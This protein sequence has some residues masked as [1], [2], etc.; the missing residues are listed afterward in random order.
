[1]SETL[2]N[3]L[4]D[5]ATDP[6]QLARFTP[7]IAGELQRRAPALS[8]IERAALLSGSSERLHYA[9]AKKKREAPTSGGGGKGKGKGRKS[10]ARRSGGR[11]KR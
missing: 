2:K 11:K 9:L 3:F 6:Q 10:A 1:M 5:V 4:V 8:E 7:D